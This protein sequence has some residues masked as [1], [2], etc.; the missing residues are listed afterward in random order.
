[1]T[2]A[3]D[4]RDILG[5]ISTVWRLVYGAESRRRFAWSV[6][7][8]PRALAALPRAVRRPGRIG[9]LARALLA[10]PVAVASSA[11]TAT[12]AFLVLIN[13]LAYPFRGWLG[14]PGPTDDIWASRYADSWGGPTLAGAWATHAGLLLLLGVPLAAWAVRALTGLQWRLTGHPGGVT[15][16]PARGPVAA[17]RR[18]RVGAAVG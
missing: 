6:V 16:A 4:V 13:V 3:G 18:R 15:G 1:M 7:A 9:A 2:S 8:V 5:R 12:L 14:L 11:L 10:I 17:A